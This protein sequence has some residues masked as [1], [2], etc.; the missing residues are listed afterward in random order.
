MKT[1]EKRLKALKEK[2]IGDAPGGLPLLELDLMAVLGEIITMNSV[3]LMLRI[4]LFLKFTVSTTEIIYSISSPSTIFDVTKIY[5]IQVGVRIRFQVEKM[6][7]AIVGLRNKNVDEPEDDPDPKFVPQLKSEKAKSLE[8]SDLSSPTSS[9]MASPEAS[10]EEVPEIDENAPKSQQFYSSKNNIIENPSKRRDKRIIGELIDGGLR[11]DPLD[12]VPKYVPEVRVVK[13]SRKQLEEEADPFSALNLAKTF[14]GAFGGSSPEETEDSENAEESPEENLPE[15]GNDILDEEDDEDL[16]DE[17]IP[18]DENES[19]GDME[20]EGITPEKME[21][22]QAVVQ[23][24]QEFPDEIN[25]EEPVKP[26]LATEKISSTEEADYKDE[27]GFM[28]NSPL[29][30]GID[31]RKYSLGFGDMEFEF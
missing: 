24:N 4:F 25:Y 26:M 19:I 30:E 10:V 15:D 18:E 7:R 14:G 5:Q 23:D 2:E 11:K 21:S 20:V 16:L 1:F 9:T 27:P 31:L 28:K 29:R 3:L 6:Y 22:E 13:K 8:D 12:F 17:L